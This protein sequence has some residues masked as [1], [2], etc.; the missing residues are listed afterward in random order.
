MSKMLWVGRQT[1]CGAG[2]SRVA[3]LGYDRSQT[4]LVAALEAFGAD[5]VEITA[6]VDDLSTFD[7][8]VSFGYKFILPAAVLAATARPVLNL[9]ISYLPHNRG[10]HPNFW[11]HVESTPAGVTIHEIDAGIDTGPIVFQ[12]RIVF[13]ETLTTFADTYRFLIENIETLFI[14]NMAALLSGDYQAEPQQGEGG[15]HLRKQLP[16]WMTDWN[17]PIAGARARYRRERGV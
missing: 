7:L 15:F 6:P 17:M 9:H 4:R 2:M 12:R 13:P 10:Y 16:G 5:V 3:F 11:S 1:E 8:C 14:D